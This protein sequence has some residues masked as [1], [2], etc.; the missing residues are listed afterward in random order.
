MVDIPNQVNISELSEEQLLKIAQQSVSET[1]R[2]ALQHSNPDLA[3]YNSALEYERDRAVI[4]QHVQAEKSDREFEIIELEN[5]RKFQK[6]MLALSL[7]I[8]FGIVVAA[9]VFITMFFGIIIHQNSML[10]LI[11]IC[12]LFAALAV[13]ASR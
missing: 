12:A 10:A 2:T 11:P 7:L 13:V 8:V 9:V 6:Q 1:M 5:R 4:Y 3:K